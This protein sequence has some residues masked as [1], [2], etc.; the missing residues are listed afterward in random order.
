VL[1]RFKGTFSKGG[2]PAEV[3]VVYDT[4]GKLS[5]FWIKPW[6]DVL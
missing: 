6:K 3:R 2:S 4:D 1:Y 5:G